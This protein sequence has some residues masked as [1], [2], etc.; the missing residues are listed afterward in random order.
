MTN[1]TIFYGYRK[2]LK[3]AF[4][5]INKLEKFKGMVI[6]RT[7]APGHFEGGDWNDGG[8]CNR[9]I[10]FRRNEVR[11]EGNSMELYMIQMEEFRVAAKAAKKKGLKYR[12]LDVTEAMLQRPDGHPSVYGHKKN[13]RVSL[14]ND[15]V[16]WCLPG[17]VDAWSDM[18]LH[19]LKIEGVREVYQ[20]G[21]HS[22]Q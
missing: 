11:L 21:S 3:T 20:H 6:L 2:A 18:L 10:P 9:T 7:F 8:K 13:E 4:K 5:A 16:H 17:P 14:Y 15:C 1:L 12:V 19:M 22:G